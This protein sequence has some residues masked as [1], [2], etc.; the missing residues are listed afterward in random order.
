MSLFE[1]LLALLAGIGVFITG[2]DFMSSS[3]R[4]V[5]GPELKKLLGKMTNN[6]FAGRSRCKCNCDYSILLS[7]NGYGCGFC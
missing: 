5:A 2:M 6:R 4:R 7:N 3:L 1:S